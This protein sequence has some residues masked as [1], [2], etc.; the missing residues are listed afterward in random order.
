MLMMKN[1]YMMID[2]SLFYFVSVMSVIV[3]DVMQFMSDVVVMMCS[4]LMWLMRCVF[5][6]LLI[7]ILMMF[8]L[9]SSLQ[10]CGDMWKYLMYMN[11]VVVMYENIDVNV[12]LLYSMC[13][14]V[15]GLDRMCLY[16][17]NDVSMVVFL[18]C[19]F[20]QVLGMCKYVVVVQIVLNMVS[21]MNMLCQL[22]KCRIWLLISGVSSGLIVVMI[23]IID[24]IFVVL[25]GL[26]VLCVIVC[27]SIDVVLVLSVC[28]KCMMISMLIEFDMKQ[29]MFVSVNSVI[30]LSSMGWWFYVLDSGLYSS[31]LIEK[32]VMKL[33]SVCC[34]VLGFMEKLLVI[35]G[36]FG[37]Y[38]LV[39]IGLQV[40]SVLS[41]RISW[42]LGWCWM[43]WDMGIWN[44][45]LCVLGCVWW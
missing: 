38:M 7:M 18:C 44:G 36:R 26:C 45:S 12:I 33:V 30:L 22:E 4:E 3:S 1:R 39:V 41:N 11:G 15:M 40:V 43:M 25:F 34:V 13:F 31:M 28:R 35:D 20:G 29:L 23:V 14:Y 24:N 17:V 5:V 37:R 8:R 27:V 6:K 42:V 2:Y 16:D 19:F 32:F 9:N 21:M 10:C